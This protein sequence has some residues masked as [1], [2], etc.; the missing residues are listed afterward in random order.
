MRPTRA[1]VSLDN[2]SSNIQQIR[3]RVGDKVKIMAVVKAD[4]Y[5][6]GATRVAKTVLQNKAEWLAV[7]TVEEALQLREEG[8]NSPILVFGLSPPEQARE[9]VRHQLSQTVCTKDLAC[10]LSDE[11]RRQQQA[12]R[13]HVEVDTGMGRLGISPEKAGRFIKEIL[14]LKGVQIEGIFTHFSVADEDKDFTQLQ[15]KRLKQTT[16]S[17]EK[18]KTHIPLK[19]AAN[20]AAIM[21]IP[22]SYFDLVRPGIM[23]YGLYPSPRTNRTL[24]LKPAMSFKTQ[25]IYL[26]KVPA[27][28]SLSYGRTFTTRKKSLIATLPVGYADGYPRAL[29]NK[30]EVLVKGK[31]A[32]V[33][34]R[35]CM[36]MTL[37]DVTHIP[38]TKVGDEVLLFGKQENEEILVDEL[39]TKTGTI[40][41]E[42]VCGISK[43]VPR[44]YINER[45]EIK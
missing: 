22:S 13:V 29:S 2:I 30:G 24:P 5:G 38:D 12:A 20:S 10:A 11:A 42:L 4:G 44:V 25:V 16:S 23:V 43:R 7:A 28:Y 14:C 19:H 39:A 27:G 33:V 18:E 9:V 26:K 35:V 41:Y 45:K 3:K 21:D 15:I 34:G 37:V 17:L 1:E 31:K 32:P 40:N 8:I 6:H 36:D